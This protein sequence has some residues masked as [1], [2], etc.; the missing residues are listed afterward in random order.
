MVVLAEFEKE[1][2]MTTVKQPTK[3][4]T[5]KF[6]AYTSGGLVALLI[7]GIVEQFAPGIVPS[8]FWSGFP[9]VLGG[10][11]AYQ[12]KDKPNH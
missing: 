7:E 8:E 6:I 3:M 11:V 4:P 10:L 1:K 5:N 9:I 12:V 2:K